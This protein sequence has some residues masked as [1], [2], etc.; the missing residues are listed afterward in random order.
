MANTQLRSQRQLMDGSITFV[1]LADQFLN[2]TTWSISSDNSAV[3][4][5]LADPSNA[6]DV[7][8][9]Q[10]VDGIVNTTF[11]APD[12]FA[13]NS[14]GDYPSDYKG[15]GEVNEGDSFYVTD[16]TNGTTVGTKTV[17]VGDML[18]ALVDN[19]VMMMLI[20][21]SWNPIEIMPLQKYQVL[22]N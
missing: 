19:P 4:T 18:V 1:K 8:N 2:N 14:N 5:G 21:S 7:V 9:K 11:K 22:L 20:G 12:G 17:N 15:T 6:N 13:T 16:V 10:Y 3:I